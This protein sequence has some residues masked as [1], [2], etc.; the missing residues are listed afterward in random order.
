MGN[1]A[2]PRRTAV[3]GGVAAA[4]L[5]AGIPFAAMT[6]ASASGSSGGVEKE[7]RCSDGRARYNFEV[8]REDGG[9][10]ADFRVRDA[11]PGREWRVK[12]FHDG[13]RFYNRV[14]TVNGDGEIEVE[15]RRPNTGGADRFHARARNLGTGAL[16]AVT[17]TRS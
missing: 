2:T 15:R 6:P 10:K 12:L 1:I 9:F 13:D 4:V 16:C 17:I 3:I 11:R 5:A 14:R 7:G 8:E